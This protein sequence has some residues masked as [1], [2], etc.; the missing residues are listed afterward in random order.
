MVTRTPVSAG[1]RFIGVAAAKGGVGQSTIS[2]EWARA[3]AERGRR[4][5]LLEVAGG[6][7]AWIV[8]VTPSQFAE[9][10]ANGT[11]SPAAAVISARPNLDLLATGN[12]WA[13]YGCEDNRRLTN[14]IDVLT[15]GPWSDCIIDLGHTNPRRA[16]RVWEA[17]AIIAVIVDDD[18]AGVSRSYAMIRHLLDLGWGD[19]LALVFNHL[20]DPGQVESLRQRFDQ[21]T[22]AFLGRTLPLIGVVPDG[23]APRRAAAVAKWVPVPGEVIQS[24]TDSEH[25]TDRRTRII[26]A[27]ALADIKI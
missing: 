1:P 6:D 15:G 4:T 14:L 26:E 10:V 25:Q 13:V 8:G 5:L 16:R 20:V 27:A 17:C 22:R 3:L 24:A 11:I 23:S 2:L 18:L 7:L 12:E 21:I 9:D 19:R